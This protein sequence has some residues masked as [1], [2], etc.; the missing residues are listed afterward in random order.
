M[1]VGFYHGRPGHFLL[2]HQEKGFVPLAQ[3]NGAGRSFLFAGPP[4]LPQRRLLSPELIFAK[5]NHKA[6]AA[7]TAWSVKPPL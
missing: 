3:A 2:L 5:W 1:A 7:G 4:D 6:E